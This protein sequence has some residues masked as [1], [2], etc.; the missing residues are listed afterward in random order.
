MAVVPVE[1][2]KGSNR[3]LIRIRWQFSPGKRWRKTKL[4]GIGDKAKDAAFERV[5]VLNEAWTK[6]GAD[7]VKLVE[8]D[9]PEK[10]KPITIAEYAPTFLSRMQSSGLKRSTLAMLRKQSQAPHPSWVGESG[11]CSN[12]LQVRS[13]FP[14]LQGHCHLQH[15]QVSGGTHSIQAQFQ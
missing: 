8:P 12:Q 3:W 14:V 2:P 4:I 5:R 10:P 15:G 11:S 1:I 9:L 7:A 13:R 6:F